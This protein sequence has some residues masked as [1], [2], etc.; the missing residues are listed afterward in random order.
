MVKPQS[1]SQRPPSG[2]FRDPAR[3]RR[4][5][6]GT[7]LVVLIAWRLWSAAREP[8]PVSPPPSGAGRS[9]ETTNSAP[10]DEPT[11]QTTERSPPA[12]PPLPPGESK[13]VQVRRIVDGDTL[14]LKD[15]TRV[16]MIGIDTPETKREG[17]PIQPFGP[18]ASAYT[19]RAIEQGQIKLVFDGERLDNYGR[20]LAHVYVGDRFLGEELIQQGLARV[21]Y[22]HPYS[23]AMKDSF[24]AAEN[25]ATR[26]KKGIWSLPQP[27]KKKGTGGKPAPADKSRGRSQDF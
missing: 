12:T 7:A 11:R 2:A 20:T 15:G 22:N 5:L 14:L 19:Q 3:W 27:E 6:T 16:R 10:P 9:P 24:R 4:I 26:E 17:T 8:G 25:A 1:A 23:D 21:L 18:E 13:I